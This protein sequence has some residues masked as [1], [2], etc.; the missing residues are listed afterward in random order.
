MNTQHVI[1]IV[2][3][4]HTPFAGSPEYTQNREERAFFESLSETY[5]PLLEVLGRLDK[6]RIPFRLGIVL[7]PTLCHKLNDETFID[8]YLA[9]TAAQIEFGAQELK[10][11]ANTPLQS[12]VQRFCDEI[13][14]R[15][16][17]FAERCEKNILKM[18][19]FYQKKGKIEL[20]GTAATHGF[21]P[22]YA[23][24]PET[25]Q[26][27]FEV[28]LSSYRAHFGRHP[29]GF[30]LPELGWTPELERYLRAY[31]FGYTVV[32]THA[33]ILGNPPAVKGSFYPVKTPHGIFVFARDHYAY[34]D[35]LGFSYHPAYRDNAADAGYELSADLI[36]PFLDADGRRTPT[37]Y[38]YRTIGNGNREKEVYDPIA[39]SEQ[40]LKQANAFLDARIARLAEAS[41]YMP[42]TPASLCAYSADAFGRLWYEGPQFL[43][44]LFREGAKRKE[45]QFMAPAEY[46]Y[47]QDLSSVQTAVP[48]FSSGGFN[49]YAQTWLDASNDW[50]Y[51]HTVRSLERMTEIAERFPDETGLKE[52]ALNQAA[53]EILLAQASDWTKMLY[54]KD[55]VDYARDQIEETLRNFTTIYEALGSNYISTEWLTTLERR[56]N[57]FPNIN[58]RVFR[59]K[60]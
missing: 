35:I 17:L 41:Q 29:H 18:F 60:R 42:E 15:R 10:R 55:R 52:R 56:H 49:G 38:K 46:L 9:Y 1:S 22:F 2:L 30:W 19:E 36:K 53:R 57:V 33:L 21:L 5:L 6:D 7:S 37:G 44:T 51:R 28:A 23:S 12:L 59:R 8:R 24:S 31:N 40:V 25:I 26:A 4:A 3:N 47:K 58:Y 16:F 20:L 50:I 43:E 32:N 27:Q 48:C 45:I 39:A 14:D 54:R 13:A 34:Q 11:T